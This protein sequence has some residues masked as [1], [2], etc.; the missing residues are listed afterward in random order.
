MGAGGLDLGTA[1]L[2]I[3][4]LGTGVFGTGVLSIG[5]LGIGVPGTDVLETGVTGTEGLPVFA[6]ELGTGVLGTGVL[7]ACGIGSGVAVAEG[8]SAVVP[9]S[10]VPEIDK[11]GTDV[12]GVDAMF[13]EGV[14]GT[15]ALG[16]VPGE[17][18]E[19]GGEPGTAEGCEEFDPGV[20]L[21]EAGTA[22]LLGG[23]TNV[24]MAVGAGGG[25]T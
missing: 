20:S 10:G 2:C 25:G 14:L 13:V 7:V 8:G 12:P 21:G 3:A 16:A 22:E 5:V 4:V 17:G 24:G 23:G 1:V 6:L 11:P 19:A 15:D 9:T 18:V